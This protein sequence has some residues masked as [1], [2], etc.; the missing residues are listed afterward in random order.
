MA[1]HAKIN[2]ETVWLATSPAALPAGTPNLSTTELSNRVK[3]Q[4]SFAS[5]RS[6]AHDREASDSVDMTL[7]SFAEVVIL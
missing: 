4:R 6:A 7:S 5:S 3:T 2:T 1:N